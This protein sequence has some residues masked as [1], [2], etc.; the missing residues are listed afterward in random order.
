MTQL[1]HSH[2]LFTYVVSID[3]NFYRNFWGLQKFLQNPSMAFE[4]DN[5]KVLSSG[6][7]AVLLAF[8]E[9]P[10]TKEEA[11]AAKFH[12]LQVK[13]DDNYFTKYL[14]SSRLLPLQ[15]C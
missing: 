5:W 12:T 11:A 2:S 9:N 4:A 6:I 14:T 1:T 10:I 13:Y 3:A 7:D 15:V 8:K